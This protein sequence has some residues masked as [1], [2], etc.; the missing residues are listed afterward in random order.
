MPVANFSVCLYAS[1]FCILAAQPALSFCAA[2]DGAA[3]SRVSAAQTA[4]SLSFVISENPHGAFHGVVVSRHFIGNERPEK[5]ERDRYWVLAHRQIQREGS[6]ADGDEREMQPVN[7][8]ERGG[9]ENGAG[10]QKPYAR[11]IHS[12]PL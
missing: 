5:H 4:T 9:G 1:F 6:R 8:H 12:R 11:R 7:R 3:R 2:S 10:G